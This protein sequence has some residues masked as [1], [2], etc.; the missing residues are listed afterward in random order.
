MKTD[1]YTKSVL[2]IIAICLTIIVLRN[3]DI[4]PAAY[5]RAP[6]SDVEP[7]RNYGLVPLNAN[8]SIDVNVKSIS[9]ELDVNISNIST[10]DKLN[11][12]VKDV[13]PYAFAYCTVPVKV[14]R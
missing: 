4:L 1:T 11:V 12:D 6:N 8:G 13:D 3:V 10:S 9:E 2:T 14:S 7:L 5:A